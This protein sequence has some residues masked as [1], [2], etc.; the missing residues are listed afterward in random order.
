M[1][2]II[3]AN[4]FVSDT[5]GIVGEEIFKFVDINPFYFLDFFGLQGDFS[6]I[7][8]KMCNKI[9]IEMTIDDVAFKVFRSGT[10]DIDKILRLEF[11]VELFFSLTQGSLIAEFARIDVTANGN[12]PHVGPEFFGL[13]TFLQENS[14]PIGTNNEDDDGAVPKAFAMTLVTSGG[15]T[16]K[17][18][19]TI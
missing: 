1:K 15:L 8:I 4:W 19:V 6:W 9:I 3:P 7:Q 11:D 2:I 17:T 5:V 16:R 10:T 12:V 13:T 14:L 18:A